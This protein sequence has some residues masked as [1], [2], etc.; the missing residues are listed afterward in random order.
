MATKAVRRSWTTSSGT[1]ILPFTVKSPFQGKSG[2]AVMSTILQTEPRSARDLRRD[3]PAALDR[4]IRRCLILQ[5]A[6]MDIFHCRHSGLHEM[7]T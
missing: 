3:V 7:S 5:S 1:F 6:I 2:P 4:I